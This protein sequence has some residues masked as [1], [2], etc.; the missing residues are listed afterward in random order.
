MSRLREG[1]DAR[2]FPLLPEPQPGDESRELSR[3]LLLRYDAVLLLRYD[4]ILL[5]RYDV[6][7]LA[8]RAR[9]YMRRDMYMLV[10]L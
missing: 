1:F 4:V 7:L 9:M 10:S 6:I 2:E 8:I 5:W 3:L